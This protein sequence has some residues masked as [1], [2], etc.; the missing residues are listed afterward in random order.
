[1]R[2]AIQAHGIP[3]AVYS[4][5]HFIFCYSKPG[6]VPGEASVI[7]RGK[8]TQFRRAMQRSLTEIPDDVPPGVG[9]SLH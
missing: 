8:P 6:T 1:M 3:L 2:G 9:G 4:D 5:R 7:D